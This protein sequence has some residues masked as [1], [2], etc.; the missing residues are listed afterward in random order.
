MLAVDLLRSAVVSDKY[1]T[2]RQGLPHLAEKLRGGAVTIAYLGGSLTAMKDGWRPRVHAWFN[3][4]FPGAQPHRAIHVGRG[5]VGSA[6][7][8]F[9]VQDEI[10][11]QEPDLVLIEYVINDSYPFQTPPELLV[12]SVEGMVR[13]IRSRHPQCEIC[14]VYTTHILRQKEIEPV[15]AVYERVADHYGLPSIRAGHYFS[16]LVAAR[17]W[18]WRGE[19]GLP[20]L[21]RDEC[22]PTPLGSEV[23]SNLIAHALSTFLF[24]QRRSAGA[25]VPTKPL[26]SMSLDRGR[27]VPVTPEMI[28]GEYAVHRELV[29]NCQSPIQWFSLAEGAKLNFG[30]CGVLAGFYVV[31]GPRSGVI[32]CHIGQR[33]LER[34]LFD[35]WCHYD[36]ISTCMLVESVADLGAAQSPVTIE[37]S[38]SPPDYRVCPSVRQPPAQ[39]TLDVIA[40]FVIERGG[41]SV[42]IEISGFACVSRARVRLADETAPPTPR[43]RKDVDFMRTIRAHE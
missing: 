25:D 36:R 18:S 35:R 14:F 29:A 34:N 7:G 30:A 23:M 9:F 8:V 37:L 17:R 2:P 26:S 38:P 16:D 33:K 22:H 12:P 11:G 3:G 19:E 41:G 20:A 40:L 6:S 39:R 5:G 43:F 28:S 27:V 13:A 15:I 10:C 1:F 21:L 42:R 24:L 4:R 31:V 32:Q